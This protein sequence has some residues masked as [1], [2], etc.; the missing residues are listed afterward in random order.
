MASE[1]TVCQVS[2]MLVSWFPANWMNTFLLYTSYCVRYWRYK[3]ESDTDMWIWQSDII[4]IKLYRDISDVLPGIR[5]LGSV[6]S[7][8]T[9]VKGDFSMKWL[10]LL[11]TQHWFL[12]NMHILSVSLS[13]LILNRSLF[14]W[15]LLYHLTYQ[16]VHVLAVCKALLRSSKDTSQASHTSSNEVEY[17]YGDVLTW[18]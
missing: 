9:K 1:S 2:K 17:F 7:L 5:T 11:V 8:I 16:Y 14:W 6:S 15:C 10:L 4:V 12:W 18:N 3:E 13:N